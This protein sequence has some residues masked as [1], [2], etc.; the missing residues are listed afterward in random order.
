M[1]FII[2]GLKDNLSIVFCSEMNVV[3]ETQNQKLVSLCHIHHLK[4]IDFCFTETDALAVIDKYL[5][6]IKKSPE[7]YLEE[8]E[9]SNY[10]QKSVSDSFRSV[11][12]FYFPFPEFREYLNDSQLENY[13][14]D[15]EKKTMGAQGKCK[16]ERNSRLQ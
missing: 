15:S 14:F 2:G 11:G 8:I 7:A 10:I 16:L 6:K 13:S 3:P 5:K 12:R 9:E 4:V 1:K